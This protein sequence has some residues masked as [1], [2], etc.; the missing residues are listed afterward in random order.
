MKSAQPSNL[1]FFVCL[2]RWYIPRISRKDSERLLLLNSNTP[3]TYIIRDSETEQGASLMCITLS[4]FVFEPTSRHQV[5]L[6][7]LEGR[8][9]IVRFTVAGFVVNRQAIPRRHCQP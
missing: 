4:V 2:A 5:Q 7:C 9:L 3:G 8:H 1:Q 6:H